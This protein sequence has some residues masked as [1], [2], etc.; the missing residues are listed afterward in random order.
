MEALS[1]PRTWFLIAL[2]NL[3]VAGSIGTMLRVMYVAELPFVRFRPWL[4]SHSHTAL[5][6]WMFIG[7]TA[8]MLHESGMQRFG[9]K[10]RVLLVMLQSMVFIMLIGFPLQGHGVV[11][12]TAS[13]I[14]MV[15]AYFLLAILWRATMQWPTNGSRPLARLAILFF[16]LSTLG[17]WVVGPFVLVGS[18]GMEFYYWAVQFF[19]HF[20]FNGWFWFAA[21]AIGTR[22]AEG[23]GMNMR[24]DHLTLTLWTVS[25][26]LTYA[27]AIAW[28]EPHPAVFTTVTIGVVLQLWATLRTLRIIWAQRLAAHAQLA[29][30][31]RWTIGIALMAMALKV[32]VQGAVAVPVLARMAL[33]IRHFVMGFVHLNTL[34]L[35]TMLMLAYAIQQEWLRSDLHLVRTGLVLVIAGTVATEGMLFLQGTLFWMGQ[36]LI[37]GHYLHMVIASA[38][39]PLGVALLLISGLRPCRSP[40]RV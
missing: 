11:P 32:L 21:M 18:S 28:S 36:G 26:V 37:P 15:L 22:W 30:W 29:K 6:G 10:V 34:G 23:R 14:Q 9:R 40:N 33:T 27:L 8:V 19:L 39:L 2:S 38:L 20:Q 35:M 13:M 12:I 17:A 5:F 1:K 25:A 4:E 31:S 16:V 3:L 7:A 24:F